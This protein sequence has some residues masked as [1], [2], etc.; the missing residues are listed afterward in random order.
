MKKYRHAG[1]QGFTLMELLIVIALLG[2]LIVAGF[3]SYTTSLQRSRDTK[4]KGDLRQ[5]AASLET[6]NN[7]IGRYP[8]TD[9]NGAIVGCNDDPQ[10]PATDPESCQWNTA[11]L[12][13]EVTYMVTLPGDQKT[14]LRYYYGTDAAGTYFQLYARLENTKDSDIPQVSG[15]PAYYQGTNC[16]SGADPVYCNYGVSSSNIA[17]S[18]GHTPVYE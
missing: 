15:G 9:A 8:A 14:S 16:S 4:R 6:Y 17:V 12:K 2:F 1:K 18:T 10:T 11:F 5:I 13:N 7:D 3:A